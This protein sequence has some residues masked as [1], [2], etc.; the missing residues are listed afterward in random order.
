MLD[1]PMHVPHGAG[2]Q[3][4]PQPFDPDIHPVS[5][6]SW[7]FCIS[8][9]ST[10]ILLDGIVRG[11]ISVTHS[12]VLLWFHVVWEHFLSG[13]QGPTNDEGPGQQLRQTLQPFHLSRFAF[14]VSHDF[15]QNPCDADQRS[16]QIQPLHT[17]EK[18]LRSELV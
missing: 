10:D 7:A 2:C 14:Q 11:S 13:T 8:A 9:H 4:P 16:L 1:Q 5:A 3:K 6:P 17:H 12:L 15:L 18:G